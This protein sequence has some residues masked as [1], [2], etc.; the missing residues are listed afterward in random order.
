[1]APLS[2]VVGLYETYVSGEASKSVKLLRHTLANVK[3]TI[4]FGFTITVT[5]DDRLSHVVDTDF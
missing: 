1:M 3:S 5:C 2:P 4:G